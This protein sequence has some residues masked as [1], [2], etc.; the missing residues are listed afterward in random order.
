MNILI[1]LILAVISASIMLLGRYNMSYKRIPINTKL[2]HL[3]IIIILSLVPFSLIIAVVYSLFVKDINNYDWNIRT[4]WIK[5]IINFFNK[6][7]M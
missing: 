4:K 1:H 6:D 7:I 3:M 2:Y 5:S